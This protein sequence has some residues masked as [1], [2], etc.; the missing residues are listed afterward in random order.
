M[1]LWQQGSIQEDQKY[2]VFEDDFTLKFMYTEMPMPTRMCTITGT[3][4]FEGHLQAVTKYK[5]EKYY[6]VARE[7]LDCPTLDLLIGEDGTLNKSLVAFGS[8]GYQ[9]KDVQL[10]PPD[11]HFTVYSKPDTHNGTT[12]EMIFGGVNNGSITIFYREY[13]SDNLAKQTSSQNLSFDSK[14]ETI[15]FKDIKIKVL[16]ASNEKIVFTVLD[17]GGLPSCDMTSALKCQSAF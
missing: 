11:P 10:T 14:A 13:S 8:R 4:G 15:E 5:G 16:E 1:I 9:L 2:I 3:K 17:D 7:S 6:V 12:R